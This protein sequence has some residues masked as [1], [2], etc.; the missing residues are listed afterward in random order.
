MAMSI[1]IYFLLSMHYERN[2]GGFYCAHVRG[3]TQLKLNLH[4]SRT[5]F[6]KEIHFVVGIEFIPPTGRP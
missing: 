5:F 6:P 4:N 2:I 1:V 3:I